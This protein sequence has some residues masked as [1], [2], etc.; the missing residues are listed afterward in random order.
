MLYECRFTTLIENQQ[1]IPL[2]KDKTLFYVDTHVGAFTV[3]DNGEAIVEKVTANQQKT[4]ILSDKL[5]RLSHVT[6]I[7]E[8]GLAYHVKNL[9]LL[10]EDRSTI[11]QGHC[12]THQTFL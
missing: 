9:T 11:L 12:T 3:D 7:K 6:T 8:N 1:F 4:F 5:T 2:L 10:G